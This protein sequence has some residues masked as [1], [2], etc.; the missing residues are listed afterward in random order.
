[1]LISARWEQLPRVA[2]LFR[3][4][5]QLRRRLRVGIGRQ[6]GGGVQFGTGHG[7]AMIPLSGRHDDCRRRSEGS[8]PAPRDHLATFGV[9]NFGNTVRRLGITL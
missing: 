2:V 1:M 3:P 5:H 4:F 8:E 7:R 6:A 9:T